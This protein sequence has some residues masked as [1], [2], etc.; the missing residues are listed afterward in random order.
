MNSFIGFLVGISVI[1]VSYIKPTE[2]LTSSSE[3]DILLYIFS[4]ALVLN[5]GL[6]LL[7]EGYTYQVAVRSLFLGCVFGSGLILTLHSPP[8]WTV[9]GWYLCILS[10]FHYSEYLTTSVINPHLVSLDSFLLNHSKEYGIA[11]VSSWVEYHVERYFFPENKVLF[12]I[13]Y[14]GLLLCLTGEFIR[15]LAMLTAG[16]NFTHLIEFNKSEGHVLVT[17]GIYGLCRHPSYLGWFL[18]SVGTQLVLCN[19][20]CLIAYTYAS[21]TFFSDRIFEEEITLLNFFGEDY[22]RYQSKVPTGLPFIS[23]CVVQDRKTT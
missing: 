21:W 10:F 22:I 2:V 16:R 17:S 13:S 9:F 8:S 19:P 23:G 6:Y 7:S 15:K 4:Y 11:A 5:I 20:L 12:V 14:T 1:S 3:S 18:W